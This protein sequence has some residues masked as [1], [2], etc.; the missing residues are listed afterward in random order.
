[1]VALRSEYPNDGDFAQ[2]LKNLGMTEA[3][4]QVRVARRTSCCT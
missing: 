3:E 4:L 2:A 1:L